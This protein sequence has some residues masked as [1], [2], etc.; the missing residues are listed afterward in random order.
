MSIISYTSNTPYMYNPIT[1]QVILIDNHSTILNINS[2]QGNL[3]HHLRKQKWDLYNKKYQKIKL[4]L[5]QNK[6]NKELDTY[7]IYNICFIKSIYK[8]PNLNK[9][10]YLRNEI[11]KHL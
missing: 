4:L 11:K 8:V 3:L 6:E 2:K 1:N 9:W 10:N 5:K 7:T